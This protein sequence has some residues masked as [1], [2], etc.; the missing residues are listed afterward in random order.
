MTPVRRILL[1]FFST[2]AAL[3]LL[4]SYRTS[5][6][7]AGATSTPADATS[8]PADTGGDTVDGDLITT[9]YGPVQ[10]RITVADSTFTDVTTIARPTGN[11][12]TEK[13]NEAA[14]P[15]LRESALA[16]R[17]AGIDTVTGATYTSEGYRQS[18][19]SA[20]DKAFP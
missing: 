20:I 18:L 6:M 17:S 16:A 4:F 1:W 15:R 10:V 19:Q 14:L 13:I 5:T 12:Q 3:A 2:A 8:T 9:E 11:P 7:G